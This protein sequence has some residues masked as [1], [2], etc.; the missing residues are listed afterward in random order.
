MPPNADSIRPAVTAYV[1]TLAGLSASEPTRAAY[2]DLIAPGETPTRAA[3]MALMSGC[4]LVAR[5][6]LRAFVAH[7]LLTQPYRTDPSGLRLIP[8]RTAT[9]SNPAEVHASSP[10]G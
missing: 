10:R 2:L 1:R 5:A 9:R 4:A 8:Q 6:V 3:E 7:P